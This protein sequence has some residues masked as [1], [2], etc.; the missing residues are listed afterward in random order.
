VAQNPAPVSGSGQGSIDAKREIVER[1]L[2]TFFTILPS[3]YVS[4][5]TGPYYTIQFQAV[6]EQLAAI[7]FDANE[8]GMDWNFDFTR[9]EFLWQIM[10]ALAFP[11]ATNIPRVPGDVSYRCFLKRMIELL[12][13]GA[14]SPNQQSGVELVV[15]E[16]VRVTVLE[17]SIAGRRP[18]SA[19]GL[20]DQFTYEVNV[21]GKQTWTT[22]D[23]MGN[24][25]LIEGEFG[26]GFPQDAYLGAQA[27]GVFQNNVGIVLKALKPA[28]ALFEYRHLFRDAINE[29]QDSMSWDLQAFYYDDFRKFCTGAK[30]VRSDDGET[31]VDRTLFS[32]VTVTFQ[33]IVPG[34]KLR[35]LSGLNTPPSQGGVDSVYLGEYQV[36]EVLYFPVG[37]DPTPRAYT[38]SPTGLVGE[39]VVGDEGVLEDTAQDWSLADEGEILTISAGP[40]EGRY[41]L[42]TLLGS[43]GGPVGFVPSGS[44]VTQVRVA[45]GLL[46]LTRRMPEVATEQTYE[47]GVDR[48]GIRVPHVVEDEDRSALFFL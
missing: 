15:G 29:I 42:E 37:A 6:A 14:T 2:N 5:I 1:I 35:V 45:L 24:T 43:N 16:N 27:V 47:V 25:I 44:G 23:G 11:D 9:S 41:R 40:N 4:Q 10:G 20:E 48:L 33:A 36:K 34:S 8:A 32:D 26:T 17:K 28:H 38:T 31:L 18:G 3:N 12:L 13:D 30:R 19:W 46:R 21:E 22:D 39:L 7:Q